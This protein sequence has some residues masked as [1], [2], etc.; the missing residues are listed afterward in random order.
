MGQLQSTAS[1]QEDV[2]RIFWDF[3]T[4]SLKKMPSKNIYYSDKYTDEKFEYRHVM[5]PKDLAKMVPKSHLMSETEW[6]SIGVQQ[7][8]GWIHHMTH[9]PEPHILLF[10]RPLSIYAN[11]N[12]A[13][14]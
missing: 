4:N 6:R 2:F 11:Q 12:V 1:R 10:R 8:Q 14:N 5:L 7:S 13:A 9:D 3:R